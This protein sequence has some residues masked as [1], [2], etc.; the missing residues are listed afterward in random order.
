M[1]LSLLSKIFSPK[2]SREDALFIAKEEC[3]RRG[4]E[5]LDPVVQWQ[6]GTW[7]VIT[8]S[9]WIGGNAWIDI[10]KETGEVIRAEISSR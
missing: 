7:L 5:W 1:N 9:N 3:L 2:I 6:L 4:W 8:N 10:D